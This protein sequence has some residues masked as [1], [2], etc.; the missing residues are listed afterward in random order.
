MDPSRAY[1]GVISNF[2]NVKIQKIGD[3][4][5]TLPFTEYEFLKKYRESFAVSELGRIAAR[6]IHSETL[7]LFFGIHMANAATLAARQLAAELKA[8]EKKRA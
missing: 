6:N 5:P 7:Q 1:S 3:I 4:Q 2:I 8:K